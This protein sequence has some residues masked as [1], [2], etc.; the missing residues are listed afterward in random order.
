MK[1]VITML[2]LLILVNPVLAEESKKYLQCKTN[3]YRN[4]EMQL[5]ETSVSVKDVAKNMLELA[6]AVERKLELKPESLVLQNIQLIL[7]E[8][9]ISNT[10]NFIK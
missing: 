2:G 9:V 6:R 3:I 8:G 10:S 7:N 1:S 4:A 5:S